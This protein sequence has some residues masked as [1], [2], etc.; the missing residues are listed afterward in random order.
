MRLYLVITRIAWVVPVIIGVT[1]MTFIISH[2]V[3]ADPVSFLLGEKARPE[4]IEQFRHQLGLDQPLPIQYINYLIGLLKGDLGYSMQ[5]RR[6]VIKDL[7]F[8]LP[9]T[10]ELTLAAMILL[11][12]FSIPL[13]LIS[14]VYQDSLIDHSLRVVSMIGVSMPPFWLG[15]LLQILFYSVLKILP[16]SNRIGDML[17]LPPHIT[18]LLTIDSLLT[19]KWNVFWD[20]VKHLILPSVTLCFAALAVVTRQVRSATL[21]VLRQPYV[22]AARAK[23]LRYKTVILRHV[24]KNSLIP[25]ITV[26]A[27]QTGYLLGGAVLTEV[28][29][30]WP[31]M[32]SWA[33]RSVL[34][35]DYQPI[36]SIALV[37]AIGYTLVNLIADILYM[38][39]DPRIRV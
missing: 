14:A 23:G 34:S 6:A 28:V 25:V 2:L 37:V 3:P 7:I 8:Y 13:G 12:V 16:V 21:E 17:I 39:V 27:L 38:F 35:V 1:I 32:G 24:L 9:A 20:A 31:G 10:L 19:G 36:M 11:T 26:L 4:Q 18:G 33:L 22:T 15:L 30:A 5:S 29:F